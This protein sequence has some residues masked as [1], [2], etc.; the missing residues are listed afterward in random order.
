MGSQAFVGTVRSGLFVEEHPD[1]ESQ[2]LLVHY[3]SNTG[4]DWE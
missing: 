1:D 3:K 4:A 2:S